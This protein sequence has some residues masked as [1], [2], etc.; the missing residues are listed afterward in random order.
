MSWKHIRRQAHRHTCAN[1]KQTRT[2]KRLGRGC[3]W[4]IDRKMQCT[5]C[6]QTEI[7]AYYAEQTKI[8]CV[9]PGCGS[10]TGR[11]GHAEWAHKPKCT[12]A[13]CECTGYVSKETA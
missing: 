12:Y 3:S 2:C 5:K 13:Y 1:C 4:R 9:R 7:K 6:N 8:T 11:G 10:G